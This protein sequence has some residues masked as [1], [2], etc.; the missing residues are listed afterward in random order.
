MSGEI[1]ITG[2]FVV[3]LGETGVTPSSLKRVMSDSEAMQAIKIC[4]DA[5]AS[6]L[7][8][9]ESE[10][11]AKKMKIG[12][13][14]ISKLQEVTGIVY[15]DDDFGRLVRI[16]KA[17]GVTRVMQLITIGTERLRELGLTN[18]EMDFIEESLRAIAHL[19]E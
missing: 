4:I 1:K 14:P 9:A 12:A 5:E 16:L 13:K 11:Q 17:Q 6:R 8:L 19:E 10:W 15:L 7:R 3:A 2:A 18:Y